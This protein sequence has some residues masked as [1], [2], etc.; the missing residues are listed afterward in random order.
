MQL[1]IRKKS[2]DVITI[3]NV[4][5]IVVKNE[6]PENNELDYFTTEIE[7][8]KIILYITDKDKEEVEND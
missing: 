7:G 4:E 2:G 3:N 1:E 8:H 5:N 6:D